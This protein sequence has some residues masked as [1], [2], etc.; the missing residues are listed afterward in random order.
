MK[1]L[2]SKP[3]VGMKQSKYYPSVTVD[4]EDFPGLKEKEIGKECMCNMK[5]L[6]TGEHIHEDDDG[7]TVHKIDLELRGM[8]DMDDKPHTIRA[9]GQRLKGYKS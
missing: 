1:D 9:A 3:A 4:A 6:K 5:M 8:D 7:K 2:G